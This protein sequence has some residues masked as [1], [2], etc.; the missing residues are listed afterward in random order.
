MRILL[1]SPLPPPVSGMG[2]WT[3]NVLTYL[4]ENHGSFEFF[5]QNTAL[6]LLRITN[7]CIWRRVFFGI[8]ESFRIIREFKINVATFSP[9]VIHLTSS[10]SLALIKDYFILKIAVRKRIPVIIHWHFGRIPSLKKLNNWEWRLFIRIIKKCSQ[11]IVIDRESYNSMISAGFSNVSY[12]PNPAGTDIVLKVENLK[13]ELNSRYQ[14]RLVFVGHVTRKKGVF[15][16]V[17]ACVM[18]PE[19]KELVLIGPYEISTRETLQ[20]IAMAKGNGKWIKFTGSIEREKVIENLLL[21]KIIVLPSYTEGFP[22][23]ILE[24]MSAGCA[25]ISSD[26]GGMPEM[27]AASSDKPCGICVPVRNIE[28]LREAISLLINDPEKTQSMARNGIE[29]VRNKYTP[30]KV[31]VQYMEVWQK[32]IE[33]IY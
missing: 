21:S 25:V 6:K 10:G 12:I 3:V 27:I 5:H 9:S 20:K 28:K 23:V 29:M 24:G 15:E 2:T 32:V 19:I 14:A 7:E 16:L 31:V 26:A 22:N 11:S 8:R 13:N 4:S 30:E 33:R 18:V 1:V 17:K